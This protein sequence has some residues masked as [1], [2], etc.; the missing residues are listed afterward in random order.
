LKVILLQ[1]VKD[2]GKQ[3]D[4]VTV[5]DGYGRNFLFPRRLATVAAGGALKNLEA[6]HAQE[7]RRD[8]KI[9]QTAETTKTKLEDKT[10]TIYAK[11]GA[12][13]L[14]GR[15]TAQDIA[16]Q[17]EKDF[18][19]KFDKRKVHL[20]TP[21]KAIGEYDVPLK[22]HKDITLPVKVSVVGEHA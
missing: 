20:N 11:S 13:K 18:G 15:I 3:G 1:D 6:K 19:I 8:E 5:A 2:T 21:I 9:R 17:I 16:D 4:V 10:I 22:L 7:E 12:G 14:Y